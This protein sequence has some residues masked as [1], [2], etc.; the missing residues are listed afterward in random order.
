[1]N[2]LTV[3]EKLSFNKFELDEHSH[4]EI[5]REICRTKCIS[6]VCLFI[7][8]AKVYKEHKGEVTADHAG[9][10]ECGTCLVACTEKALRWHYP[11]GGFGIIYRNG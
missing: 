2:G 5:D 1:M 11:A 10:L 8:P 4:I 9:C 3:P 6:K 7:C